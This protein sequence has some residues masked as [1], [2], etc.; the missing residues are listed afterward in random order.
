MDFGTVCIGEHKK[1]FITIVNEGALGTRF[2]VL[3]AGMGIK[4]STPAKC[5]DF[6]IYILVLKC[7]NVLLYNIVF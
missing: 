4:Q 2:K 7:F 5:L 1:C 6:G 3:P